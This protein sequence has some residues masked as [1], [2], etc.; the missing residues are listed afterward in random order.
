MHAFK[1]AWRKIR[2]FA[3]AGGEASYLWP[4]WIVLRA[5]GLVY[6]LIFS[7]IIVEGRALIGPHG[8][9]PVADYCEKLRGIFPHGLERLIRVPSLFWLST[10]PA[11][12]TVLQWGGLGAAVALILNLWP[13]MALFTCWATFLSFVSTWQMFSPTIIDQ[14]LLET[15]L[16]CIFFAPAGLRPG[17]G[18]KSPPRAIA[19]F[20][21]RWL[22][23]RIM[24]G[25][26]L[27][28]VFAGD[29]HWRD[30][31]ALDVMYETSP[32]PTILGYFDAHLPHAY[33]VFEIALTLTAELVAP[34][35]AVFGGRRGRWF[36][37]G[38]WVLLQG[39]DGRR[40]RA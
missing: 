37:L 11:M 22:L 1:F 5:V 32:S 10:D 34:V 24:F 17:L 25:S 39:K 4:R 9:V 18:S 29:S 30:L 28:K 14:L 6:L 40:G 13:Q 16:L 35:V 15:A 8:L 33:H 31:T 27:I 26:G 38:S 7:G 20:M 12:I 2:D 23:F 36:A 3:G 19:T 21:L